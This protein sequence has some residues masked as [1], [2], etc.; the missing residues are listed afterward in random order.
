MRSLRTLCVGL[1]LFTGLSVTPSITAQQNPNFEIGLKP[2]GS[3]EI[4]TSTPSAWAMVP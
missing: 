3:Y 1:A 2:F 4:G